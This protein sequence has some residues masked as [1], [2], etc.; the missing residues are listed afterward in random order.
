MPLLDVPLPIKIDA[1]R[2]EAFCRR[3][4]IRELAAF[5]SVL[6]GDFRSGSDVDLLVSFTPD[7]QVGLLEHATMQAEL[8]ELLGRKVDLVSRRAIERSANP[9]RRRAILD[10]AVPL[11]VAG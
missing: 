2:L 4:K 9:I 1:S 6:R 3:W 10:N 5:G 8:S 11:Y 7:A